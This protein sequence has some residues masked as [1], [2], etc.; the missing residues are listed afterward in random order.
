MITTHETVGWIQ[1]LTR[2]SSRAAYRENI[3]WP[4]DLVTFGSSTPNTHDAMVRNR[5]GIDAVMAQWTKSEIKPP[6][7]EIF[8]RHSSCRDIVHFDVP[9]RR[10]TRTVSFAMFG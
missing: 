9:L 4:T 2:N 7:V 3:I 8:R 5:K 10:S 1:V 6:L